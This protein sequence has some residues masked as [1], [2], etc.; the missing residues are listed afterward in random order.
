MKKLL[1][2]LV[3]RYNCEAWTL[4]IMIDHLKRKG[5]LTIAKILAGES[6]TMR[7]APEGRKLMQLRASRITQSS[8][9]KEETEANS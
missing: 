5:L 8:T 6:E 7:S 1:N 2:D 4:K 3:L 9:F